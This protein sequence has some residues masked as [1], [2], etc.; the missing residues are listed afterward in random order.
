MLGFPCHTSEYVPHRIQAHILLQTQ[1]PLQSRRCNRTILIP[2]K[3]KNHDVPIHLSCYFSVRTHHQ[4]LCSQNWEFD[5]SARPIP[6]Y[7]KL[8]SLRWEK[9]ASP[10][11]YRINKSSRPLLKIDKLIFTKILLCNFFEVTLRHG[12]SP[13]NVL[14]IFRI[15]FPN[16]TS[17]ELL[18]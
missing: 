3:P 12:C 15:P 10:I 4:V 11:P 1:L 7:H 17:G 14:H 5:L 16:N 2:K 6:K 18:L 8:G 9:G 13:V